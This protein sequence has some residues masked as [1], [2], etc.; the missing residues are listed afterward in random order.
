MSDL[1][2]DGARDRARLL[3]CARSID[4][5]TNAPR[6]TSTTAPTR[7]CTTT[8]PRAPPRPSVP[9]HRYRSHAAGIA[10]SVEGDARPRRRRHP[11]VRGRGGGAADAR[12]R[13]RRA[14]QTITGNGQ[15]GGSTTTVDPGRRWPRPQRPS[16]RATR[17][18]RVRALPASPERPH[19]RDPRVRRRGPPRP[20]PA[21]AADLRWMGGGVARATG[22]GPEGAAAVARRV[23][24]P[25]QR[26][27][28]ISS[29]VP[30]RI[31]AE[32]RHPVPDAE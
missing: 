16:P 26:S 20:E 3:A 31:R 15:L 13:Q 9:R 5:E 30:R 17:R 24:R 19:R 7:C 11:R 8:T 27:D 1:D 25:H 32:G 6:A 12:G 22:Q 4:L 14:G 23:A 2:R 29:A 21:R 18:T 28:Q 10:G